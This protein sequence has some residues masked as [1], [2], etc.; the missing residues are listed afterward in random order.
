MPTEWI[1]CRVLQLST[2]F[3]TIQLVSRSPADIRRSWFIMQHSFFVHLSDTETRNQL[4]CCNG[5]LIVLPMRASSQSS[6]CGNCWVKCFHW[7]SKYVT[8][9]TPTTTTTSS[10]DLDHAES[11]ELA[12]LSKRNEKLCPFPECGRRTIFIQCAKTNQV[13]E[14]YS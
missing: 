3:Y 2:I 14:Y 7:A 4:I 12:S 13:Y 11:C 6:T 9:N 1:I 5:W 10:P 8:P